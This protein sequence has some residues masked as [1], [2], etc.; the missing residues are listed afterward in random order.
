MCVRLCGG[1]TLSLSTPHLLQLLGSGEVALC[2]YVCPRVCGALLSLCTTS[3]AKLLGS[4]EVALRVNVCPRSCRAILSLCV[5]T[6]LRLSSSF[7]LAASQRYLLHPL[8]QHSARLPWCCN[9]PPRSRLACARYG[10]CR[11]V[12]LSPAQG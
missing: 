6:V 9:R 1:S 12:Q 5:F 8:L 11:S 4:G 10:V 7:F 3:L 2:V